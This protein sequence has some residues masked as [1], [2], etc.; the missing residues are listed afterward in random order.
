MTV[1]ATTRWPTNADLIRDCAGLGYLRDDWRT[2]D[3]TWGRGR[4]WTKWRPSDLIAHDLRLDGVDFR[5]LPHRDGEF[6]CVAFDPP[7]KLCLD[8]D[9]EIL[10]RDGWRTWETLR[11]GDLAYTINPATGLGEWKPVVA[12]NVYP[13]EWTQVAVCEGK[14][15]DFVA[16]PSHRWLVADL[17]GDLRWKTTA[18]LSANDRVPHA[19]AWAG[20]PV[21]AIHSDALVELV[22]WFWTEGSLDL[23][24]TYGHITQSHAVNPGYCDRIAACLEK[25]YGPAVERMVRSG[26]S[27]V[28][29]WRV[30]DEE[31]NRRFIFSASIGAELS[32]HAPNRTPSVAFLESLTRHQLDLFIETSM[33]ADGT[34]SDR[35]TQS[36]ADRAHGFAVACVLA[37]RPIAT[38]WRDDG[39][40]YVVHNKRRMYSKPSRPGVRSEWRRLRVWC[41]TVADHHTWMARRNGR[42]YFTGNSGTPASGEF[43]ERYGVDVISTWQ[44]RHELIRAGITECARVLRAGGMFLLKCQDQVCSGHVRWQTDEFTRHAESLGLVKVDRFDLI[45]GRPQPEGRRQVHAR[46]NTSTLLVFRATVQRD[47]LSLLEGGA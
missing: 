18:Q 6:D 11:A 25:L 28:P 37:G 30:R 15:L 13:A 4:W 36:D 29:A 44:E 27:S 3:P 35:L 14:N 26:R 16:T 19:A 24:S 45:G 43:D 12:V 5:H 8:T 21:E 38:A 47:Q 20:M 23:P 41:P 31:R 40:G 32:I 1:L 39:N 46:R 7:Y 17:C 33:A 42:V 2:L 10:T 9:T 22:A 34:A